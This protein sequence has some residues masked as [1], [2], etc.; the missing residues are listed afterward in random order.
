MSLIKVRFSDDAESIHDSMGRIGGISVFD[1]AG[2]LVGA[3]FISKYMD[4]N[5][6]MTAVGLFAVGEIVHI[7]MGKSTPITRMIYPEHKEGSP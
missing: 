6:L 1:T 7:W 2:T 5:F 4:Y 3:Y